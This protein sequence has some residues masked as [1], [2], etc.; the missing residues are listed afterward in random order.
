M[1]ILPFYFFSSF[2]IMS[3][4]V[5]ISLWIDQLAIF[6]YKTMFLSVTNLSRACGTCLSIYL[7]FIFGPEEF[8]K[9][10]LVQGFFL[11]LIGIGV[12]QINSNYFCSNLL[13]YKG[14]FSF[15]TPSIAADTGSFIPAES[16]RVPVVS[17]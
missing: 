4:N 12:T 10:F 8:K 5:F 1:I 15:F 14:R 13:T 6:S 9:S 16:D 2:C 7:N 11:A 3:M 17:S